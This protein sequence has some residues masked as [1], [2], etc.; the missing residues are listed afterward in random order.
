MTEPAAGR[1]PRE[2]DAVPHHVSR[3]SIVVGRVAMVTVAAL[4]CASCATVFNNKTPEVAITSNPLE[5]DVY[6]DGSYVGSTPVSVNL[7]IRREHVVVFRKEGFRDRTYTITRSAGFGWV[8]LDIVGGLVPLIVDAAT[9][10]WFML[11]TDS[12]EAVLEEA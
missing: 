3:L 7:S 6:V 11:D 10:D 4:L 8:V 2:G 9:G 1:Q 12:V 5:A